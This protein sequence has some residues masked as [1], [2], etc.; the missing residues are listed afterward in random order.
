MKRISFLFRTDVHAADKNPV[1][2]KGDYRSE[3]LNSLIQIGQIAKDRQVTAV[4][5][6]GD[7][8]HVKV[9]VRTS[10][11]LIIDIL[12]IHRD[13]YGD[14]YGIEGNHDI[15]GNN[16]ETIDSQ[17]LGVLYNTQFFKPLRNEVFENNGLR[18]RVVGFPYSPT[19]S[20]KE[21][22]ALR[23]QPGDDYMVA[24][25][26]A[27]AGEDP[28]SH[29]EEFY[30]EPVFRYDSLIY[31]GGP[32]VLMFGHWHKDQGVVCLE[33]RHFVNLGAV[34]R[35]SL[36]KD[37]LG[38]IPKV[39]L[40]EFTPEG[41]NIEAI[42]LKVAAAEEVYDLERKDRQEKTSLV[43]NQFIE[44]LQLGANLDTDQN[45]EDT[46]QSLTDTL[47]EVRTRALAYLEAA[48][49]A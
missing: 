4:L 31:E 44:Q 38:R 39:A 43:I 33:G 26:H 2:W 7:F 17:P 47:P 34:S 27:L 24:V 22:Q 15:V 23:K 12:K 25:I 20:L 45:I 13:F 5:D 1:S 10:H 28:P 40:V 14:V 8:F 9:A 49:G 32:D 11:G 48:R 46:I 21:I 41:I 30:G 35:G 19:R 6:G 16:L 36:N 37:N 29:I 3:I 42:P 18:V